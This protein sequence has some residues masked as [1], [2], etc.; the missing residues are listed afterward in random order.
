MKKY[1]KVETVIMAMVDTE[2]HNTYHCTEH[3]VFSRAKA[4]DNG[5]CPRCLTKANAVPFIDIA[6]AKVNIPELA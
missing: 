2:K 5:L 4:T 3:G 1:S 6:E